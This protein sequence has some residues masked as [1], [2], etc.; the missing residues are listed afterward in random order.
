MPGNNSSTAALTATAGDSPRTC[1]VD[2]SAQV[3]AVPKCRPGR[4]IPAC[5]GLRR[6]ESVD[7]KQVT[8]S[9]GRAHGT[10]RAA[11]RRNTGRGHR[12]PLMSPPTRFRLRASSPLGPAAAR[13]HDRGTGREALDLRLDPVGHIHVG[14]VR[15]VTVGPRDVLSRG[16]ARRVGE[17]RLNDQNERA[18]GDPAAPGVPL[19]ARDLVQRAA[20]VHRPCAVALLGAPRDRPVERP[21]DLERAR[22]VAPGTAA[23]RSDQQPATREPHEFPRETS[24]STARRQLVRLRPVTSSRRAPRTRQASLDERRGAPG[25][26]PPDRGPAPPRQ[27]DTRARATLERQH[28]MG[29]VTA[30][31]PERSVSEGDSATERASPRRGAG[32]GRRP[33]RPAARRPSGPP[34]RRR[35]RPSSAGASSSHP[36]PAARRAGGTPRRPSPD[37]VSS[38]PRST[39][40]RCRRPGGCRGRVRVRPLDVELERPEKQRARAAAAPARRRRGRTR[41]RLS[42]GGARRRPSLPPEPRPQATLQQGIAAAGPFGPDRPPRRGSLRAEVPQSRPERLAAAQHQL[43]EVESFS[44]RASTSRLPKSRGRTFSQLLPAQRRSDRCAELGRTSRPTRSS[45]AAVLAVVDERAP[46]LLQPLRRHGPGC[47]APTPRDPLG[48]LVRLGIR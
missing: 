19:R 25:Q 41:R 2:T 24:A 1:P 20:E 47:S 29:A 42:A 30:N 28:R 17:R 27:A 48:E 44:T 37:A 16:G 32:G 8:P 45:S 40:P 6:P 36:R 26:R 31:G 39:R 3:V 33:R 38:S 7:A 10:S 22:P 23:V 18:L 9:R 5:R 46:L 35:G 11:E 34:R 14:A 12:P 21:V 4:V 13:E 15:P 43:E